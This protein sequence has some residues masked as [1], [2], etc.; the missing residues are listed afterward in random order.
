MKWI[1]LYSDSIQLILI[2]FHN[3][4]FLQEINTHFILLP[5]LSFDSKMFRAQNDKFSLNEKENIA[6]DME[7]FT[8]KVSGI[9]FVCSGRCVLRAWTHVRRVIFRFCAGNGNC[10]YIACEF[11]NFIYS[12]EMIYFFICF[13][14]GDFYSLFLND[15]NFCAMSIWRTWCVFFF[16]VEVSNFLDLT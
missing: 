8:L 16:C 6:G 10:T 14:L 5:K 12:R 4:L 7:K 15:F 9:F 13:A 1:K 3:Y 11:C 2:V